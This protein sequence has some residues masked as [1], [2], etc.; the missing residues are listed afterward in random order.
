[1]YGPLV[2]DATV[3]DPDI[4][5]PATVQ[6]GLVIKPLGDDEIVQPVSPAA[7][8]V[9]VIRT[10]VPARPE[11]GNNESPAVIVKLAV[12]TSPSDPVRVTV[13]DPGTCAATI[14][15]P[16]S[17]PALA[18]QAAGGAAATA[19]PVIEAGLHVSATAK[20]VPV[21]K[22]VA[23]TG[24]EEG[25][26]V[27]TCGIMLRVALAETG[28]PS[29]TVTRPLEL[30][31]VTS[32]TSL[33]P[34]NVKSAATVQGPP[35]VTG[36]PVI[37]QAPAVP[38]FVPVTVNV[39]PTVAGLGVNVILGTTLKVFVAKSRRFPLTV[40]TAAACAFVPAVPTMNEPVTT[41]PLIV[42][43]GL[44]TMF[45]PPVMVHVVSVPANP[46]P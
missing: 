4:A 39:A 37:V 12:P 8:F 16:V 20:P 21:T 2:P 6:S 33:E 36:G 28:V 3:N 41:P 29:V 31:N 22:I 32:T 19:G 15:E 30:A 13:E 38:K 10:F 44:V 27:T 9:P 17:V 43:V 40:N 1:V 45:V 23:P 35:P 7:K 34:V 26:R 14:K 18:L 42:Q 5:P 24:P 11:A 25:T 46:V